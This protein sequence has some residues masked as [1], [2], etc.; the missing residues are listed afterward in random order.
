MSKSS[1]GFVQIFKVTLGSYSRGRERRT[2]VTIV[3]VV[4]CLFVR[5]GDGKRR[6]GKGMER[7]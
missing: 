7:I 2:R 6:A 3:V 1:K 5:I 4:Y